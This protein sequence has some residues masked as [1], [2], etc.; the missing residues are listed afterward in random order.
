MVNK[1]SK[2]LVESIQFQ[3]DD[4]LFLGGFLFLPKE[5]TNTVVISIHGPQ[6]TVVRIREQ[7]F[8]HECTQKKI[9]Y[10]TFNNRS[11]AILERFNKIDKTGKIIRVL[12]GSANEN[13]SEGYYDIKAAIDLMKKYKFSKI[14]IIA[15]SLSAIK[16]LDYLKK[17]NN[18]LLNAVCFLSPADIVNFQKLH[19]GNNYEKTFKYAKKNKKKLELLSN[20]I[21]EITPKT[22]CEYVKKSSITSYTNYETNYL[23][24]WK[25][26][27]NNIFISFVGINE[28]IT[29]DPHLVLNDIKN[30]FK[31]HNVVTKFYP[32]SRH[33]YR[34]VAKTVINDVINFIKGEN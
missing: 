27:P 4:G 30:N 33:S 13:L 34:T 32:N 6:S 7:V 16:V 10:F 2:S 25:N 26:L 20:T 21:L 31:N 14:I 23:K 15:H 28:V 19:L 29:V 11:T 22:F 24:K 9:A 18:Y 8:A 3:T 1:R 5:K 12:Y 17:Y